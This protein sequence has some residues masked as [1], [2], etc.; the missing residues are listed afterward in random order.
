M[1]SGCTPT[2]TANLVNGTVSFT[3]PANSINLG[4]GEVTAFYSGDA[5]YSPGNG[6]ASVTVN[7]SGTIKP[8]ITVAAPT[9]VVAWPF[10]VTI[11]VS[12]PSGDPIPTGSVSGTIGVSGYNYGYSE[13]LTNGSVTFSPSQQLTAGPNTIT[14]SYLGDSN[15]TSGNGATTVDLFERPTFTFSAVPPDGAASQALNVTLTLSGFNGYPTPTGTVTL[16]YGTAYISSPIPLIAGSASFTIPANT[17]N[18]TGG[19]LVASYSGDS[20]YFASIGND[21]VDFTTPAFN[22]AASPVS[23]NPGA[24][25]GNTSAVTLTPT[26]GFT[27]SVALTATLT[28]SP[29]GAQDLPTFTFGSTTPVSITGTGTGG[30]T[31]TITT[32][33]PTTS[34]LVYPHGPGVLRYAAGGSALACVLLICIPVRRR[35]W[36]RVLGML[37]LLASFTGLFSCGGGGGSGGSGGGGGGGGGGSNPG[38]TAG[39]YTITVT[40][41]SGSITQTGTVVLNVQ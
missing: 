17:L 6:S 20:Y 9:T 38:T 40:A 8:T 15:Y 34:T 1:L 18:V 35:N 32:T 16:S 27:G 7:S 2:Q 21:Y 31:L 36:R 19:T 13:P 23:V 22:I 39:S 12:G 14:A 26:G 24:V 28:S 37:F 10:F 4:F 25:T 5:D 30:A 11:T 33:A 29:S 3:C 41:T